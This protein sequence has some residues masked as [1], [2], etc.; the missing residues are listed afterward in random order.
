MRDRRRPGLHPA[1]AVVLWCFMASHAGGGSGN[2]TDLRHLEVSGGS[3]AL[4]A[5]TDA[6]GSRAGVEI[7]LD[8]GPSVTV[9]SRS[10]ARAGS[11]IGQYAFSS[12][13]GTAAFAGLATQSDRHAAAY[14]AVM[15]GGQVTFAATGDLGPRP[16]T[17]TQ[18]HDAAMVS[19]DFLYRAP[20]RGGGTWRAAV[21]L[22]PSFRSFSR[23]S[24]RSTEMVHAGTAPAHGA[25]PPVGLA[26]TAATSARYAGILGGVD[27][28]HDLAGGWKLDA[29]GRLG[30][31]AFGASGYRSA[32]L[33][34][35]GFAAAQD[36]K[37]AHRASGLSLQG[38]LAAAISRDLPAGGQVSFGV[39]ADF[40]GAAPDLPVGSFSTVETD[41]R[42]LRA[43]STLP[44]GAARP[45]L[46][47]RPW[48]RYGAHAAVTFRF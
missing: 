9:A 48:W 32:T 43:R 8:T 45:R 18:S 10:P 23:V 15:T 47:I 46:Q 41:G 1:L 22:G 29:D 28:T 27:I 40:I 11:A 24:R 14:A 13:Q 21:A 4:Q 34:V 35:D 26:H 3:I 25:I 7:R 17:S 44:A 20:L 37:A 38:G 12:G 19:M 39:A 31:A 2:R 42:G 36:G 6:G 30:I 33:A 16:M 5:A